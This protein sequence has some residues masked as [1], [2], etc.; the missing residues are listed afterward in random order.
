MRLLALALPLISP[1]GGAALAQ[2]GDAVITKTEARTMSP[3]VL[4]RRLFGGLAQIMLPVPDRGRPG[5][6]PTQPLRELSFFTV[7][8][9]SGVPGLCRTE[10]ILV[11]FRLA[12]ALAGADT[13]VR[14]RRLTS[15]SIL[16]VRDWDQLLAYPQGAQERDEA[17]DDAACAQIDPRS[18]PTIWAQSDYAFL[19]SVML[20]REFL[21]NVQSGR[22]PL[23]LECSGFT[24]S[25]A[26]LN[27]AECRARFVALDPR[28]ATG[29]SSCDQPARDVGCQSMEFDGYSLDFIRSPDGR[30]ITGAR[31]ARTV[32]VPEE[33]PPD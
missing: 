4:R 10:K 3:E 1:L 6:R 27:D 23:S 32:I 18:T 21:G 12:G 2:S 33:P 26:T 16:V 25:E 14:P 29:V 24:G 15:D 13:P 17:R 28:A 31:L 20:L 11:E 7:P 9:S 8:V 19:E 5:I 30:R 22:E